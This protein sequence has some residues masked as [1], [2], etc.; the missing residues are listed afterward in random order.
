MLQLPLSCMPPGVARRDFNSLKTWRQLTENFFLAEC[1]NGDSFLISPKQN[2]AIK[3]KAGGYIPKSGLFLANTLAAF[4]VA[5]LAVLDIGTGETGILA[6]YLKSQGADRVVGCDIDRDAIK[7]AETASSA[8]KDIKW[9]VS[10]VYSAIP[11]QH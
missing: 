3:I 1:K 9:L 10:D 7:H 4:P 5:G 11:Q 8:S 2:L 6:N